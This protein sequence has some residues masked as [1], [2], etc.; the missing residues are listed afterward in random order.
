MA[1][2]RTKKRKIISKPDLCAAFKWVYFI[3]GVSCLWN[4]INCLIPWLSW[5]CSSITLVYYWYITVAHYINDTQ[6]AQAWPVLPHI[7]ILK[8][9]PPE[10]HPSCIISCTLLL[11]DQSRAW[12][13]LSGWTSHLAG[14]VSAQHLRSEPWPITFLS[15]E[16]FSV[17][18]LGKP[19]L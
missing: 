15:P 10:Q 19:Q 9:E 3:Y 12:V 11:Y 16:F 18:L 4:L 1:V 8:S 2:T 17:F 14:D 13:I 6:Q 7:H 5:I